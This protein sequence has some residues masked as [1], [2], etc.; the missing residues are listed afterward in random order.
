L[1]SA[2]ARAPL[3]LLLVI[4]ITT[5]LVGGLALLLI[6]SLWFVALIAGIKAQKLFVFG[7]TGL[8]ALGSFASLISSESMTSYTRRLISVATIQF[9]LQMAMAADD[10]LVWNQLHQTWKVHACFSL[11]MVLALVIHLT[12][13]HQETTQQQSDGR[14]ENSL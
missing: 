4:V 3:K 12:M 1:N 14:P 6:P 7:G 8:Y 9:A 13:Q 5:I 10:W 11:P 2:S